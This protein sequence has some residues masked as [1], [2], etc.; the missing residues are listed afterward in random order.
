MSRTEIVF[1]IACSGWRRVHAA[2][3]ENGVN[4]MTLYPASRRSHVNVGRMDLVVIQYRTVR[5]GSPDNNTW[6]MPVSDS[7]TC[8]G[9]RLLVIM[10]WARSAIVTAG[11][12]EQRN[13]GKDAAALESHPLLSQSIRAITYR[14][15]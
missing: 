14:C 3:E 10:G 13:R 2:S 1:N 7:N 8:L 15:W 11:V 9:V 6:R 12:V 5:V 4:E